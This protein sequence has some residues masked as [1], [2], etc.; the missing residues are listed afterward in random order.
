METLVSK[1]LFQQF[2]GHGQVLKLLDVSFEDRQ[3]PF[4]L[5]T[6]FSPYAKYVTSIVPIVLRSYSCTLR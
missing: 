1:I 4:K 6:F 2:E 5:N 3:P